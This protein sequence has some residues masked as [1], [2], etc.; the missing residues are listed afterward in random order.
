MCYQNL[1]SAALLFATITLSSVTHSDD[2][3]D[4][5]DKHSACPKLLNHDYRKLHSNTSVNLCELYK[6]KA[7]LLVNTASHCGYTKQFSGL[8]ELHQRFQ[9]QGLV[10]IGFT[11][12]DF[13]Q[14]AKDEEEAAG[15]CYKNY[16]V[17]F[18]MLAPTAVRGEDANPTFK[19]LARLSKK[20]SWNF[21]K[22]L[23]SADGSKV[24][25]FGSNTKPMSNK[26]IEAIEQEL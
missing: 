18:T 16:G 4:A 24:Q 26:L 9:D 7:I 13:K 22:Y 5:A 17:S 12:D 1:I 25:R 23:V 20:P 19:E 15:I 8:E 6:G 21:N 3:I 2:N 11:S 14:A 10:V